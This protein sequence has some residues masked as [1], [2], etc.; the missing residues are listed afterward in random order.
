MFSQLQVRSGE[1]YKRDGKTK[2]KSSQYFE[3]I[4]PTK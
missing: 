3:V 2:R 1:W 4:P